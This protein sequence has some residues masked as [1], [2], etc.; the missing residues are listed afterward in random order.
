MLQWMHHFTDAV[1][2]TRQI[3]MLGLDGKYSQIQVDNLP[4]P[5]GLSVVRGLLFI[6]GI[7]SMKST[8]AREQEL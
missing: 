8:S 7:G 4:G 1:T 5:R 2:G 6:P 3:R